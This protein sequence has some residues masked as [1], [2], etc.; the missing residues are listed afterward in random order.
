MAMAQCIW[1]KVDTH[2]LGSGK[3]IK[4]NGFSVH[5]WPDGTAHYGQ[6]KDG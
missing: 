2:T 3:I 4:K 5:T 1:L 6:M